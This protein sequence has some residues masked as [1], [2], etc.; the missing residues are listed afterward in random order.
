MS[1]FIIIFENPHWY[2]EF[3]PYFYIKVSKRIILI[4]LFLGSYKRH[5]ILEDTG[6]PS[7]SFEYKDE[8]RFLGLLDK[9][10]GVPIKYQ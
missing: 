10:P 2:S 1:N 3:D 5:I 8:L 4:A 7:V 6:C 9:I